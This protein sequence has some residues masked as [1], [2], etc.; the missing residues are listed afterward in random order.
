[1]ADFGKEGVF[2]WQLIKYEIGKLMG[3]KLAWACLA[4]MAL[5][6]CVMTANWIYPGADSAQFFQDG[7]LVVLEGREGIRENQAATEK[8]AGPL[9]DE[10]VRRILEDMAM[11]DEDMENHG[12]EPAL[13]GHYLHN[14]LFS[15]LRPF[16]EGD[17][18]WNGVSVEEAYGEIADCLVLGYS[19]G[20]VHF[21]YACIYTLLSM[22]C[23]LT[24][25][26]APLFAEEYAKGMDALILTG[27]N[28]KTKCAWAKIIAGFMVSMGLVGMVVLPMLGVYLANY[29]PM[30]WDASIQVNEM[31]IFMGV[32]YPMTCGQGVLFALLLWFTACLVLAAVSMLISVLARN[33]FSGLVISFAVFVIPLFIPWKHMGVLAVV[34]EF[35]PI[36]QIQLQNLFESAPLQVGPMG[37]KP[38]W[39]TVPVAI[40]AVAVCG[41]CARRSFARHQVTGR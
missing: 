25:L 29:G 2:M 20:W 39:I 26:L 16:M 41:V 24:I 37:L 14:S 35:F 22:G 3:R 32:P 1:M 30:G 27:V 33:S 13:E 28:G 11:A 38:V 12:L 9:T 10:K 21:I 4:G 7:E 18:S 36:R 31:Q 17:G 8:Y 34:A 5:M 15:S 40:L 23:V 6:E 19:S